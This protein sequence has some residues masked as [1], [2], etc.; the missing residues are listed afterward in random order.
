VQKHLAGLGAVTAAVV[1]LL[2]GCSAAGSPGASSTIPGSGIGQSALRAALSFAGISPKY[3]GEMRIPNALRHYASAARPKNAKDLL[4]G[5]FDYNA[6]EILANKTWKN[7]GSIYSGINGPLDNWVDN[8]GN[9]YVV[10]NT[11][12]N[13]TEY[14]PGSSSPSFTY[15]GG[16]NG[17][18]MVTTD[19]SRNVYVNDNFGHHLDE[20]A[21]GKN[22]IIA[23]CFG[24]GD[25]NLEGIAVDRKGD[26]F[27]AYSSSSGS[28]G[29]T[30][31]IGGL[32]GC[33]GTTLG[34][35]LDYP[36]GMI[37][38]NKG[39]LVVCD[40]NADTVDIIPPP[41]SRVTG[42]LGSGYNDPYRV[43]IN[44]KNNR[45]YVVNMND[46]DVLVLKYPS[47]TTEATLNS[48]NGLEY[49]FAAVDSQNYNP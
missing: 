45:A 42:T 34:V 29:I 48:S 14:A 25:G 44:K 20:F 49:P 30:E 26:V 9:L 41:Y 18:L 36:G 23:Q 11:P 47:G 46:N 22:T 2:S 32:S 27:L 10:N 7:R 40:Q 12:D 28:G 31:Y 1:A 24:P 35:T 13:I 17:P 16:L 15:S 37:L 4:V 38:D 6:V 5:D 19:S 3:L 21:Q 43:T 33:S 8:K 39:N